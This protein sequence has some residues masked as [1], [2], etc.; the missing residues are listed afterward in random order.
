VDAKVHA[1]A[2]GELLVVDAQDVQNLRTV[3]LNWSQSY[4]DFW[5]YNYNA[6]VSPYSETCEEL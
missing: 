4:N 1:Q 3:F 5:I 2:D 6:S